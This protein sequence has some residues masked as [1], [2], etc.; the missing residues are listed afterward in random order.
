MMYKTMNGQ[1]FLD[2]PPYL[3]PKERQTRQYHPKKFISLS[4]NSNTYKNSFL[5]RTIAE[6]NQIPASVID[7]ASIGTF[8]AALKAHFINLE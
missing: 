6:W 4:S 3:N 8:K 2:L 7:Q 5:A 1:I